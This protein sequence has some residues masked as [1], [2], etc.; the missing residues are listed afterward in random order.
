MKV[1]N[2]LGIGL[3]MTLAACSEADPERAGSAEAT[4]EPA[5]APPERPA[6]PE[7]AAEAIDPTT[8][9]DGSPIRLSALGSG[10]IE[11]AELT[12]ELGCSFADRDGDTLLLAKGDV[13]SSEPAFGVVKV[14]DYVESVSARGGFDGMIKGAKF[15]G[16]GKTIVVERTS[17]QPAGGGE[18]PPYPARLTYQRADGASRS[19]DGQWTCGP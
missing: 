16:R 8:G 3:L 1:A 6:A 10:D 14:G 17:S 15:H 11:G 5:A 13:A 2:W 9:G 7:V 12:G 18:S 4:N 19:F